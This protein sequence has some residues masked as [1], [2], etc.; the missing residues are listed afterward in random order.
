VADQ[1]RFG[2]AYLTSV[3]AEGTHESLVRAGILRRGE[4]VPKG[5]R[6]RM[7]SFGDSPYCGADGQVS[8]LTGGLLRV[9]SG[10]HGHWRRAAMARADTAFR[11]FLR[12][13][14]PV[15]NRKAPGYRRPA[16]RAARR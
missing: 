12:K 1:L 6:G 3:V 13:L 11:A 8:T 15:T 4:R 2:R 14:Q 10:H 9:T 5:G 7:V 16:V